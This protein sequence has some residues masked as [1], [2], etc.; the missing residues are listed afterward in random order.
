MYRITKI[1][2]IFQKKILCEINNQWAYWIDL[3]PLL[4]KHKHFQGIEQL[5][6]EQY[7]N[8][9]KI[10]E[11]GELSWE[12]TILQNGIYWN[13]DVSAEFIVANGIQKTTL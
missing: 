9:V 1:L 13:Y 12:K 7:F 5:D 11:M 8:Q 2:E 4:E 10:G 3:E 6:D